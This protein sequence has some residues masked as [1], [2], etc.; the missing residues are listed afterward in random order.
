[1]SRTARFVYCLLS[2]CATLGLT[3]DSVTAGKPP[4]PEE[5][6][7]ELIAMAKVTAA[8]TAQGW[9][10]DDVHLDNRGYDLLARRHAE[11]RQVEVKGVWGLATSTGIRMTGNEVL[12]A[13]QHRQS[14]WLYVVDRCSDGTGTLLGAFPDP[15]QLLGADIAGDMQF[16]ILGKTLKRV[17][18]Q[19]TEGK[20]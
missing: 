15:L 5:A 16:R 19:S 11:Q 7:S 17:A 4:T 18:G 9:T 1:M 14:Y 8:L 13:A 10:V 20:Q 12:I 2:T 3:C 6:D